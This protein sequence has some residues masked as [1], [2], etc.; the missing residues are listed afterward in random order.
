MSNARD[1]FKLLSNPRIYF[2]IEKENCENL[3]LIL[4]KS[5]ELFNK[6]T[7]AQRQ[8]INSTHGNWSNIL[9]VKKTSQLIS[10]L[11]CSNKDIIYKVCNRFK[12]IFVAYKENRN[13]LKLFN[14]TNTDLNEIVAVDADIV[15][16]DEVTNDDPL[17]G[18]LSSGVAAAAAAAAA[19]ERA[20]PASFPVVSTVNKITSAAAA[21]S[22]APASYPVFATV[23]GV[24]PAAA[25]AA[26][27]KSQYQ[28]FNFNKEK[29]LKYKNKYL[30][31]KNN[32]TN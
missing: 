16:D 6:L 21:A 17:D 5:E 7:T 10:R 31:L 2:N 23:K 4:V 25:S 11:N 15:E 27:T 13:K 14:N 28:V 30:Q 3:S 32:I 18:V 1:L 9:P 24:I 12:D 29:Y 19:E 20:A 26:P 8:H 22:A